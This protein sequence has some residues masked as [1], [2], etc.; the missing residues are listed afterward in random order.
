MVSAPQIYTPEVF[1]AAA[2]ILDEALVAA[3]RDGQPEYTRRIEFLR[4]GLDHAEATM[5]FM[6]LLDD[7][8][9]VLHERERFEATRQAWRRL[10]TLR[11]PRR[12]NTEPGGV[13]NVD[14]DLYVSRH[15]L[16]HAQYHAFCN[17]TDRPKQVHHQAKDKK[18]FG[19]Y[20]ITGNTW[21]DYA[22]YC[23][24]L[25]ERACLQPAYVRD[26]TSRGGWVLRDVPERLE[27]YRMPSQRE[28]EYAARGGAEA[29]AVTTYAGSNTVEE[30]ALT[31]SADGLQPV[32]KK[33]P[34]ALG[35]YDMS[36][37]VSEW[38]N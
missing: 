35:L 25:S 1:A 27:G 11:Q 38:T 28:W 8:A 37:L 5:K 18:N 30:V 4:L 15:L 17:A 9:V 19:E 22:Q 7:G 2:G 34:N 26:E 33:K 31:G 14:Y 29:D 23:N 24:W 20:P 36:G 13:M 6:A 12:E 16:T 3:R 32:G 10:Q 21:A